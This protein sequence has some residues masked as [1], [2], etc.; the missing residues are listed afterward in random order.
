MKRY[1]REEI[2]RESGARPEELAELEARGLL[3]ANRPW[4]FLGRGEE[5]FTAGQLEVL[6]F[7]VR[8]RR[9]VEANQP[10]KPSTH[11]TENRSGVQ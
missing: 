5:Y 2:V 7:I 9:V 1:N 3:V 4:S 6:R 11:L 8:A 10:S